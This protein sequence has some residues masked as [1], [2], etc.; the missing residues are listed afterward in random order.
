MDLAHENDIVT[1]HYTIRYTNGELYDTTEGKEPISFKLNSPD[2]LHFIPT[3][4]KNMS[5][6]EVKTITIKAKDAFG[7]KLPTLIKSIKTEAI[8]NHIKQEVGNKIEI[9]Q[10]DTLPLQA[11]IIDVQDT[12][13]T[14]DANPAPIGKDLVIKIEIIDIES[15]NS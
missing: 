15:E 1:I 12:Y 9:Q 5:I 14:I 3:L 8:P 6:G 2:I 4:I 13:I 7:E 10:K 11:T